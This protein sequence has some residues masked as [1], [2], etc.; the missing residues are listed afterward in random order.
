VFLL[1]D[2]TD[3]LDLE[4]RFVKPKNLWLLAKGFHVLKNKKM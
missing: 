1:L 3:I 2:F 4:F